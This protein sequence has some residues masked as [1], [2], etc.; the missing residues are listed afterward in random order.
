[1]RTCLLTC[2]VVGVL[3][4]L[5]AVLGCSLAWGPFKRLVVDSDMDSY[6][7]AVRGSELDEGRKRLLLHKIEHLRGVLAEQPI[8]FGDWVDHTE[9][10]D[11]MVEDGNLTAEE[12]DLLEQELSRIAKALET[13]FPPL[14]EGE[15]PLPPEGSG[16]VPMPEPF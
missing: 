8:G 12:A 4:V 11:S 3:A 7:D 9:S 15:E 5:M 2:L 1:M 10:L 13:E 6:R 14:P 16:A